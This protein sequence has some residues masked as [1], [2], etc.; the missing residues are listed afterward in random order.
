ML[1]VYQREPITKW[2]DFNK[3]FF[4]REKALKKK[5]T[6]SLFSKHIWFSIVILVIIN[7]I[8]F[9]LIS[10]VIATLYSLINPYPYYFRRSFNEDLKIIIQLILVILIPNLI[11]GIIWLYVIPKY[12]GLPY[13]KQSF[14]Q[15]LV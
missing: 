11:Y 3:D 6:P 8:M 5:I 15:Q 4:S 14:R 2:T 10:F 7:F 13:G 9:F 1:P 12:V